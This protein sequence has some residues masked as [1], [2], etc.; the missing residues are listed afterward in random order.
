MYYIMFISNPHYIYI[1]SR[2]RINPE[3]STDE[4]FTYNIALPPGETFDRVVCINALIP[5]S[6]YLIQ[7]GNNN[8]ERTLQLRENSTTVNILIPVGSYLLSTFKTI[9]GNLLTAGSPN[10]LTYVLSYPLTSSAADTGKWTYTQNNGSIVSSIITNEH[11]YEPLG[12]NS[13]STNTFTGTTLI[14]SNVIKM[15]SEDRLLIHSNL[16]SNGSDDILVSINSS[17][18]VNYSS[19]AWECPAPAYYSHVLSSQHN[20]VFSFS[21]TDEN[22][23]RN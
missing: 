23:E 19:I 12:F 3:A 15:Q 4:N 9:L 20:N 11:L 16:V 6:Y 18:S 2:D 13:S 1:N 14:S 17:T 5:K 21:L 7:D 10:S 22:N 8:L